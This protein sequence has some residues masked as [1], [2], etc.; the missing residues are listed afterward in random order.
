MKSWTFPVSGAIVYGLFYH[1]TKRVK[2]RAAR[3]ATRGKLS[4][5]MSKKKI[6]FL[7]EKQSFVEMFWNETGREKAK[8]YN[9]EVD[10]PAAKGDLPGDYDWAAVLPEYDGLITTWGSPRCGAAFLKPAGKAAVI[11]HCA[12]SVAAVVD[13]TTYSTPVRVTTANPV[14]AEA[15][16]EWSLLVTMLAQRKFTRYAKLRRDDR[17]NWEASRD[18]DDLKKMTIGL[19]GL[20]DTTRHLLKMLA[21]LRPGRI[22]ICSNHS[23]EETIRALGGEKATLEELLRESDI[24]HCL[25]GV[26]KENFLKI[27]AAEFGLMKDGATFI[28]GG[29]AR[30]TQEAALLDVLRSGRINAI[31]DVFHEEPLP[32]DSP[33][34]DLDN[35]IYTPHNA[36]F[37]G[38]DRFLPFLLDEFRRFFGGEEMESEITRQRYLT[39]TNESLR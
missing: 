34:N 31:L 2:N 1:E 27:G 13:E 36:G 5:R 16:A 33:F 9:F 38:R 37:T 26:S 23:S 10:F 30:L 29:R 21:P 22:L 17:M 6:L 15:V 19:W 20:G 12:G 3:P 8:K 18:M 4:L 7:T 39:M 32:D 28:N 35:V 14:M 11:G 25:V 24:F